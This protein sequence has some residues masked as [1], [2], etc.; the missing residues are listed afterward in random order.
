MEP[1]GSLP[2]LQVPATAVFRSF[3]EMFYPVFGGEETAVLDGI[4]QSALRLPR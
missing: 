2:H 1:D 3:G 4:E